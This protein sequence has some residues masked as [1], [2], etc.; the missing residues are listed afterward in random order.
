MFTEAPQGGDN[1]N[2][3]IG[4]PAF[5]RFT[6]VFDYFRELLYLEPNSH[7]DEPYER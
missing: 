1:T 5:Q 3:I 6:V 4:L 7:F 2:V